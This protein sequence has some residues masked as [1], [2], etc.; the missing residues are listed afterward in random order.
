M[1]ILAILGK[2]MSLVFEVYE[3]P[4]LAVALKDDAATLA[5]IATIGATKGDELL[6]TEVAR[7]SATV[8]RARKNLYV[9]NKV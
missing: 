6:A 9:I 5:A 8:S 4:V 3:G 2:L 7:A 1:T